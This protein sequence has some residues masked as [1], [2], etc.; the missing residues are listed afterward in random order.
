V[1][2]GEVYEM[3]GKIGDY[4]GCI[5]MMC[6]D[7]SVCFKPIPLI[8]SGLN[9]FPYRYEEILFHYVKY[10]K[11]I[12]PGLLKFAVDEER[13]KLLE[14][15]N[16][17]WWMGTE[18][19]RMKE[20]LDEAVGMKAEVDK[21][22]EYGDDEIELILNRVGTDMA[23]QYYTEIRD[24][25]PKIVAKSKELESRLDRMSGYYRYIRKCANL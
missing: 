18:I 14:M 12:Y 24:N 9:G 6:F 15:S 10:K 17:R 7:A 5:C 4:D 8:N 21:M 23:K 2:F 16:I 1:V 11:D 22:L 19:E 25:R 20:E 3:H 13:D